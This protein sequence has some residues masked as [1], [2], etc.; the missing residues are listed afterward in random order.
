MRDSM[1]WAATILL[2][3][4]EGAAAAHLVGSPEGG[5]VE[6]SVRHGVLWLRLFVETM[7]AVVI[8]IGI[9]VA[10]VQFARTL[11][12]GD[13]QDNYNRTRLTLA[14]YLALALE[15]QLGA[16]ILSTAIA[17]SWDQIGKLGAIAVIRTG[18]NYFLMRE[19]KQERKETRDEGGG[20][21][22]E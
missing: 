16:D 21:R 2:A 6:T 8:C 10:A 15:F 4:Q 20:M 1:W 17:P 13:H 11:L 5:A 3:L 12:S 18:L 19:M 22:D 7:G 14:R 9:V